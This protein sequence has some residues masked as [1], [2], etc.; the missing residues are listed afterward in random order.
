[1][2]GRDNNNGSH[3]L[4]RGGEWLCQHLYLELAKRAGE[5][6][7]SVNAEV[8]HQRVDMLELPFAENTDQL[9]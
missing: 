7:R 3:G 8:V 1:M 5:T 4:T 2:R 6:W 9:L